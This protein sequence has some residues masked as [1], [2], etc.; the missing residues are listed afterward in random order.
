MVRSRYIYSL[1]KS[2][3]ERLMGFAV[4]TGG[5]FKIIPPSDVSV[6]DPVFESDEV[7]EELSG[8]TWQVAFRNGEGDKIEFVDLVL[9]LFNYR[10]VAR[11][12]RELDDNAGKPVAIKLVAT[13]DP[14]RVMKAAIVRE[15]FGGLGKVSKGG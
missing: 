2:L 5:G 11:Q 13:A 4:K 7:I 3:Q 10:A 6:T 9:F 14:R 12:V 15:L 8:T 1:R